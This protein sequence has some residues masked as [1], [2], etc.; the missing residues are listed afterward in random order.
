MSDLSNSFM[1]MNFLQTVD[2]I[3]EIKGG[4][5]VGKEASE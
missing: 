5:G 4:G 3:R 1:H 2:P